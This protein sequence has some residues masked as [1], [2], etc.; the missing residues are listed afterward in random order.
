MTLLYFYIDKQSLLADEIFGLSY[1]A[2]S[3]P[4]RDDFAILLHRQDVSAYEYFKDVE[5]LDFPDTNQLTC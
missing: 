5:L 3:K 4:L 2:T 1:L